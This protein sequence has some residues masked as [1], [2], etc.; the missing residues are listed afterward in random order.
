VYD[1]VSMRDA[2]C[3][4]RMSVL[5]IRRFVTILCILYRHL[6]LLLRWVPPPEAC[7]PPEPI[8]PSEGAL[9]ARVSHSVSHE[10]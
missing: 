4:D 8:G 2:V 1:D 6:D 5:C 10:R 3:S 7:V 9:A